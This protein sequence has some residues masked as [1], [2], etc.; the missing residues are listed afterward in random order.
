[1]VRHHRSPHTW[2]PQRLSRFGGRA[3]QSGRLDAKEEDEVVGGAVVRESTTFGAGCASGSAAAR[4]ALATP[5]AAAAAG[6]QS[7]VLGAPFSASVSGCSV[8]A[9]PGRKRV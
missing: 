5:K 9:I 7:S 4:A 3:L 8:R 6:G 1:M 2:R